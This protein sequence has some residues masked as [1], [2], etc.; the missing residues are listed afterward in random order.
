MHEAGPVP[1]TVLA[2]G[3]F[4]MVAGSAVAAPPVAVFGIV[5]A[6]LALGIAHTMPNGGWSPGF[7]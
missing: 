1:R 6:V 7:A 2:V 5:L 3:L 4:L